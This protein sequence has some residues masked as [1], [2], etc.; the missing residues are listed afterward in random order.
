M[1]IFIEVCCDGRKPEQFSNAADAVR[2]LS[3]TVYVNDLTML[4]HRVD[5]AKVGEPVWVVYGF[6]H[7]TITKY[8]AK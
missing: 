8:E 6:I 2:H 1:K 5:G 3:N 4:Q 7:A